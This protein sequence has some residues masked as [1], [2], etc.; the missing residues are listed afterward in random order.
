MQRLASHTEVAICTD[1]EGG[2]AGPK[3]PL[4]QVHGGG[5]EILTAERRGGG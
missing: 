4:G 3:P 2:H 1:L 5:G